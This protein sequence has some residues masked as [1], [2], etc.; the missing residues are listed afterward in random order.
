MFCSTNFSILIVEIE[1]TKRVQI[2]IVV[3][4]KEAQTILLIDKGQLLLSTLASITLITS[5]TIITPS[6]IIKN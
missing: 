6:L 5:I 3:L 4:D 2:Q 1:Q